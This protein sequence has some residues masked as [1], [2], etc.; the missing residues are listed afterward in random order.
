MFL[1][2]SLRNFFGAYCTSLDSLCFLRYHPVSSVFSY[3]FLTFVYLPYI[4]I[5]RLQYHRYLRD[6]DDE[7]FKALDSVTKFSNDDEELTVVDLEDR[8]RALAEV[9]KNKGAEVGKGVNPSNLQSSYP[10]PIYIYS[11][12]TVSVTFM[13][14]YLL[15]CTKEAV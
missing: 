14:R 13:Q 11:K 3:C 5:H 9:E 12:G 7:H 4:F 2:V 1:I 8:D 10:R 15:V 6:Q